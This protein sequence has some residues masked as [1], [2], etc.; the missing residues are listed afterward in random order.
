MTCD[1]GVLAPARGRRALPRCGW[2][3]ARQ[4]AAGTHSSTRAS[5]MCRESH[6][7]V[8]KPLCICMCYA[9]ALCFACVLP[10]SLCCCARV[11]AAGTHA[12]ARYPA[13][14]MRSLIIYR[15]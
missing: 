7:R 8:Y 4:Q 6:M 3:R 15:H 12:H 5:D 14:A 10:R 2:R 13:T 9:S 1:G 11:Y